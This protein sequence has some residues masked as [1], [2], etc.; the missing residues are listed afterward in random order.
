MNILVIYCYGLVEW[1]FPLRE[2]LIYVSMINFYQ[3]KDIKLIEIITYYCDLFECF[4]LG[5]LSFYQPLTMYYKDIHISLFITKFHQC[6]FLTTPKYVNAS[7]PFK[8]ENT[9]LKLG[10]NCHH[11]GLVLLC[12]FKCIYIFIRAFHCR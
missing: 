12:Q 7:I 2:T 8:K 10:L 6:L 5:K 9:Y 1:Q 4:P 11:T 3:I